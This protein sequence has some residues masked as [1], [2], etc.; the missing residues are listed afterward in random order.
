MAGQKTLSP[1]AFEK[2]L[3]KLQVAGIRLDE[4]VASF[5]LLH[6]LTSSGQR[7]IILSQAT[8]T[9]YEKVRAAIMSLATNV[10]RPNGRERGYGAEDEDEEW[11]DC[12]W[13]D[14]PDDED[15]DEDAEWAH[16]GGGRGRGRGFCAASAT[17]KP[18]TPSPAINAVTSNPKLSNE[19]RIAI[20]T[21]TAL[22]VLRPR[23]IS[24]VDP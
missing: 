3:T 12:D 14:E 5:I 1:D 19:A 11:E 9:D 13:D 16:G 4:S 22:I 20:E 24:A 15:Y 18:P 7:D 2:L 10:K 23:G 6:G 21:M 17:A 8:C